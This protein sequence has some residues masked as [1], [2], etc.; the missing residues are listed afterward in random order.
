MKKIIKIV[1]SSLLWLYGILSIYPLI[2]MVF[3]SF[4]NND[5]IFLTNP[6]GP[7]TVF[8]IENYI[9]AFKRY[10]VFQYFSNS[11]IVTIGTIALTIVLAL[12]FSYATTRMKWKL[13]E[14]VRMYVIVGMF[15]PV[16]AIMI[17]LSMLIKDLGLKG[18]HLALIVPYA[19]FQLGFSTLI[20]HA[21]YKVIPKELEEACCID[22][23]TVIYTFVKVILPLMKPAIA[24]VSIFVFLSA[25]NEF[26]LALVLITD[27]SLKTLPLGILFFQGQ[28]TT[29]W[30][31]MGAAMTIASLPTILVYIFFSRQVESALTSAGAVK[32]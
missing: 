22:G 13:K 24:T 14:S 11:V 27:K 5:E 1:I 31:G 18:T 20:F 26:V 9:G 10:N 8:R 4:K 6:F 30:G 19:A 21:F 23:A 25:W 16:Q 15:I 12:M 3:Y 29:D 32:G 2:W 7:P 28:F 17:P